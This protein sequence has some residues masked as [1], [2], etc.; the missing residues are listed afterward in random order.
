MIEQGETVA[1]GS[2]NQDYFVEESKKS[3]WADNSQ[4]FNWES[5]SGDVYYDKSYAEIE[6]GSMCNFSN[7]PK[8]I[9]LSQDNLSWDDYLIRRDSN[10]NFLFRKP[11]LNALKS[12]SLIASDMDEREPEIN[13]IPC[14]LHIISPKSDINKS[15]T[16]TSTMNKIQPL[17][18]EEPNHDFHPKNTPLQKIPPPSLFLKNEG[19]LVFKIT[20]VDR[21]TK[22]ETKV[23]NKNRRIVTKWP[24]TSLKYYAKGMW[25]KCYHNFGREKK[26]FICGHPEKPLY[27][28]GYWK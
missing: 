7:L 13:R 5:S 18:F 21:V 6:E 17:T 28:K 1:I 22:Q 16:I 23:I 12:F 4:F 9:R 3:F 2:D 10:D 8:E 19:K 26:A 11:L 15:N 20:R 27:A 25:K 24:H 14:D